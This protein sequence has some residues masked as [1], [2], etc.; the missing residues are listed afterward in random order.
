MSNRLSGKVCI[1]TGTGGGIGREAA[2]TFAREG[3]LVIGCGLYVDDA[4]ATLAAVRAA[5]GTRV[6][7]QPC[8]LTKPADCQALV[9]FAVRTLVVG[10]G[11]SRGELNPERNNFR[12][13]QWA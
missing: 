6:S 2:L 1:V 4:E 5:G 7:M 3:A 13:R 8:D 9:D 11:Q 12:F 10:R